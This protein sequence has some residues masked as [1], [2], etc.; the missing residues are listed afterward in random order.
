M[1]GTQLLTDTVIT[2]HGKHQKKTTKFAG[3]VLTFNEALNVASAQNPGNF[4]VRQNTKKG[5]KEISASVAFSVS[6]N[7]SDDTVSLTL[8]GKPTF[9][10]GGTLSLTA[11]GITDTSGDTLVGSTVF[12][13]SPKADGISG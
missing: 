7:S 6:Y 4:L 9:T 5:K 8:A 2:G 13:I 3:F 10:G 12:T 11:S 1:I